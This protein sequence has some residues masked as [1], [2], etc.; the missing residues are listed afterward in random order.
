MTGCRL[1]VIA[2]DLS[3]ALDASAPFAAYGADAFG[4]PQWLVRLHAQLR[5][6][7]GAR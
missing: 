2:D 4:D 1:V 7:G 3:G 5:P 6:N